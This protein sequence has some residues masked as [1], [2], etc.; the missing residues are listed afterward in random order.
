MNIEIRRYDSSKD[1]KQ[2]LEIIRSEGEEWK[3]YLK[4]GYQVLLEKSITYVACNNTELCGFSRSIDDSGFYL[5]V[6]DLLVEKKYRG[7]SIGKKLMECLLTDYPNQDVFVMSDVD[8]YYQK[9]GYKK[10][11]SLFKVG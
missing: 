2:L 11:G 7:Y 6:I 8:A 9:L 4:P 5:W 10:E 3:D 1:Y